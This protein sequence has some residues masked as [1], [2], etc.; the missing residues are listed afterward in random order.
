MF[1]WFRNSG[2]MAVVMATKTRN[3]AMMPDSRI[4][5]TRSVS[6]REPDPGAA[7]AEPARSVTVDVMAPAPAAGRWRRP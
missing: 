5:N 1:C 4:R 6:R 7:P 2:W 3:T